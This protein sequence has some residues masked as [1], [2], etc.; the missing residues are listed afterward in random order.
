MS[1]ADDHKGATL[2][3]FENLDAL[4]AASLSNHIVM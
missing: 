4:A 1:L 2:R 3:Y